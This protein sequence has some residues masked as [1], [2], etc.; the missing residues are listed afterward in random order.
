MANNRVRGRLP[1]AEYVVLQLRPLRDAVASRGRLS[2][3]VRKP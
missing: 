3:Q 1:L 2:G